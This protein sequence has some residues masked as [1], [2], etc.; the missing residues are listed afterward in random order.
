MEVPQYRSFSR[1]VVQ[2][3]INQL[4][5]ELS[6]LE[7][8]ATVA[9]LVMEQKS[10]G[11]KRKSS[12]PSSYTVQTGLAAFFKPPKKAALQRPNNLSTLKV[13]NISPSQIASTNATKSF[14]KNQLIGSNVIDLCEVSSDE[15]NAS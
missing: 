1:S 6:L 8:N 14:S 5:R 10:S 3:R 12:S 11:L 7:D 13:E 4:T 9:R 2:P 15:E